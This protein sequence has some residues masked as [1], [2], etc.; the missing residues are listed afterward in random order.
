MN[1]SIYAGLQQR[2]FRQALIQLLQTDYGILGSGRVL[3]L[4]AEDVQALVTQFYPAP[5]HLQPGWM[6][7]TGVKAET[8]KLPPDQA[9]GRTLVSIPWPVLTTD[10]VQFLATAPDS[11]PHR[12][13]WFQ[14]RL[15]R[16]VE[17]GWDHPQ[18]PV[19]LTLTDLAAMLGLSAH[20]VSQLLQQARQQTGK[21]LITKGYFY[22]QGLKPSHKAEI[23]ALYEQGFDELEVAQRSGHTP[24]SVGHYLRDYERVKV[25]LRRGWRP[26]E[27]PRVTNMRL[28]V[29]KAYADLAYQY[30][31]DL[32][33][34]S[35]SK[36]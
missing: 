25:L 30:H 1:R 24:D 36:G 8:P 9:A 23:V 13:T 6:L 15:T 27:M 32:V 28:S 4:L 21:A 29:V 11:K 3:Q 5:D 20:L 18:G 31:P 19:L 34:K 2:T 12:H 17:Y 22:D 35:K 7:F 26:D 16:L 10:D 33:P 14:R